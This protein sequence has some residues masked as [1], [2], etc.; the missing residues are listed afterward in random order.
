[1]SHPDP[2]DLTNASVVG[3]CAS[4]RNGIW[5]IRHIGP[6]RDGQAMACLDHVEGFAP[7]I[8]GRPTYHVQVP[9][10]D[11]WDLLPPDMGPV[12]TTCARIR[13]TG[14]THPTRKDRRP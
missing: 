5:L 2:A 11:R 10:P 12:L 7:T 3:R 9:V 8:E 6:G 1:M 14:T 13:Q 4:Y